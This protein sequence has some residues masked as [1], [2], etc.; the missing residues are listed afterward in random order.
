MRIWR[1]LLKV[2][3]DEKPVASTDKKEVAAIIDGSFMFS[4]IWSVCITVNTEYRKAFN[5]KFRKL[6]HGDI[7]TGEKPPKKVP[8]P[9][10]ATIYDYTFF[11]AKGVWKHWMDLVD[12][13]EVIPKDKAA[14][15]IIVTT[16]DKVRYCHMLELFVENNIPFIY[17]GPTGT[18]KSIYIQNSL[19][20]NL[21]KSKYVTIEIGYSA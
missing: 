8:F 2:F 12:K 16:V 10:R 9:D 6:L 13:N 4:V 3:D 11:P 7:D 18:G 14:R 5:D 1:A 20:N 19:Q 15:E 21:E 17:V